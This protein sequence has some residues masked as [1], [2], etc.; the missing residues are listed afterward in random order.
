MCGRRKRETTYG[1]NLK[2]L[3]LVTLK[4]GKSKSLSAG[5]LWE[6]KLESCKRGKFRS[7]G[8]I[9]SLLTEGGSWFSRALGLLKVRNAYLY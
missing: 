3:F 2:M 8:G 5:P 7:P 1:C 9:L 6:D 4:C